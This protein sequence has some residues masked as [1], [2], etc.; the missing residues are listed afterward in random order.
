M[1]TFDVSKASYLESKELYYNIIILSCV[2]RLS[3][4]K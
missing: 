4:K 2:S 1:L 3:M